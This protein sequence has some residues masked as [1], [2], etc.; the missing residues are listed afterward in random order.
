MVT[1][2]KVCRALLQGIVCILLIAVAH[3]VLAKSR[4]ARIPAKLT[5]GPDIGERIPAISAID[6]HGQRRDFDDIV[7]PNGA[8]ILFFRSADW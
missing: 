2:Q 1:R 8:M 4:P 7:G 3:S 5:T 6:Q